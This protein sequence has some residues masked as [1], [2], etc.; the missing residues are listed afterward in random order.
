MPRTQVP[1]DTLSALQFVKN[2]YSNERIIVERST[3]RGRN[4]LPTTCQA[5][6]KRQYKDA[7]TSALNGLILL[8]RLAVPDASHVSNITNVRRDVYS[9]SNWNR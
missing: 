5:D 1:E 9:R 3:P 8:I 7:L 4:K 2:L 6:H